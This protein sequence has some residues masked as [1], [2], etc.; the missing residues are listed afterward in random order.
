MKSDVRAKQPFCLMASPSEP[1]QL[2]HLLA[3]VLHE[4]RS[5]QDEFDGLEIDQNNS[6]QYDNWYYVGRA[7]TNC[8]REIEEHPIFR[9]YEQKRAE[10][11][12]RDGRE[13]V[14]GGVSTQ[15][16]AGPG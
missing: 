9:K 10:H 7:L 16:A 14:H 3:R 8:C 5:A 6:Y 11:A 1:A 15:S 13:A 2:A 4:L 12:A